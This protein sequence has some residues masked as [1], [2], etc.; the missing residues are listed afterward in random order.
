MGVVQLLAAAAP[1][2]RAV[3]LRRVDWRSDRAAALFGALSKCGALT[4]LSISFASLCSIPVLSNFDGFKNL[5]CLRLI[6]CGLTHDAALPLKSLLA[7]TSALSNLSLRLN[8]LGPVGLECLFDD[9]LTKAL[10]PSL[11][12]ID[13]SATS[14]GAGG[15]VAINRLL[16]R[17]V[18]AVEV[19]LRDNL[20]RREV[21]CL[22]SQGLWGS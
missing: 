21:H 11:E 3:V 18:N 17:L 7:A 6:S 13:L 5:S 9:A 19:D 12:R 8:A 2:L 4:E 16:Q 20:Y 1:T 14:C 22:T 15:A 10:A